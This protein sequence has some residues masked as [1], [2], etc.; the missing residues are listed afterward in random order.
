MSDTA[1]GEQPPELDARD[2]FAL[3]GEWM[4]DARRHEPNDPDAMCIASVDDQGR[5]S[6]RMVL[7][8]G[9]DRH[10]FVFYTNLESRKGQ[11]LLA[12]PN[13]AMCMH[14]KSLA[15]QVRIEGPVHQVADDE[16][17]E[18][19]RSRHRSSRIG[20]WASAQSRPLEGRFE[21]ERKVAEY[22]AKFHI[23]PIPRP[24]HWSGFRCVPHR[25]EFWRDGLFRLHDR[26]VFIRAGGSDTDPQFRT[27]R[28]YP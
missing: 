19:F 4:E 11:E 16:A 12:N 20:A 25:I 5:P 14:W 17:D 10:G 27:E 3:F 18:Y 2:P 15:K 8:K 7:M 13:I 6:A 24:P 28:L 1:G 23:G 9:W 26:L 21:L 22:T